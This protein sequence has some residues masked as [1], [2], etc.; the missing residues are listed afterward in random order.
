MH[1]IVCKN[2][3]VIFSKFEIW[4]KIVGSQRLL[5]ITIIKYIMFL[6]VSNM[7]SLPTTHW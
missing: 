1:L 4:I 3:A 6:F 2:V 5:S 7:C